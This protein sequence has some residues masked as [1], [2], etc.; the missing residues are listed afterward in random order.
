MHDYFALVS[1]MPGVK[2]SKCTASAKS[3]SCSFHQHKRKCNQAFQA[4][5]N[6]RI[7]YVDNLNNLIINS[8]IDLVDHICVS[9]Y[10]FTSMY[11]QTHS[12][13]VK[14]EPQVHANTKLTAA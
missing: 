2:K 7:S 13:A 6:E 5:E 3:C 9:I 12:I 8:K 10:A 1:K 4:M 14:L 11:K